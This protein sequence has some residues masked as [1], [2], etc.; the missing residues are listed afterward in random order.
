MGHPTKQ[1]GS[2]AGYLWRVEE[3]PSKVRYVLMTSRG[4]Y[5]GGGARKKLEADYEFFLKGVGEKL[6]TCLPS[7]LPQNAP[8]RAKL[9]F[10]IMRANFPH[11][12]GATLR[13]LREVK[14][15]NQ[16][17]SNYR[18]M[19]VDYNH[20][21]PAKLAKRDAIQRKQI[22]KASLKAKKAAEAKG[23]S[24]PVTSTFSVD[25]HGHVEKKLRFRRY[26]PVTGGL[27]VSTPSPPQPIA[28]KKPAWYVER[29][30]KVGFIKPVVKPLPLSA[31]PPPPQQAAY[32][33]VA[34]PNPYIQ[35]GNA[36]PE[37]LVVGGVIPQTQPAWPKQQF[38]GVV[39]Y[40][41]AQEAHKAQLLDFADHLKAMYES[42]KGVEV[43]LD[44]LDEF[45]AEPPLEEEEIG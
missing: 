35:Y 39:Y 28:G 14:G 20:L 24:D 36:A 16:K 18:A 25:V 22:A 5:T 27:E 12:Y 38:G 30:G 4:L 3:M 37:P 29:T 40:N 21:T 32:G 8:L 2:C 15:C 26:N 17:H 1:P 7:F 33:G 6:K 23:A 42:A 10:S 43:K 31:V 11:Y 44:G 34:Y 45:D 13:I 41:N 19:L 9:M